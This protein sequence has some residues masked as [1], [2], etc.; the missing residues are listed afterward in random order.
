M[1]IISIGIDNGV[2][3]AV[4]A[5]DE[6]LKVISYWDT[7]IIEQIKGKN[8]SGS[9]KK[10]NEY[11]TA[12]MGN[13][14]RTLI[15]GIPAEISHVMV[16]IEKAFPMQKQGLSSTFKTGQGFGLWEGICIGLG[17]KYDIVSPRAWQKEVLADMPAGDPKARSMGKCQ[18]IFPE[19]PLKKPKGR[20]LTLDGR[21]DSAMIA[22]YGALKMKGA[23]D[24]HQKQR[25]TPPP[26]RPIRRPNRT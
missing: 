9:A 6:N 2:Q 18:R 24:E 12:E 8:K 23:S 4:T 16:W 11:A 15:S 19:I 7:P 21:A 17:I 3:G 22:Y 14:L 25:R 20:K 13:I 1:K 10:R 5:V 26:K